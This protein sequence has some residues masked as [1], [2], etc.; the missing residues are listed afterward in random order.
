MDRKQNPSAI[1]ILLAVVVLI[2]ATAL[3]FDRATNL[4]AR[5]LDSLT[6]RSTAKA[7]EVRD[8]FVQL[9]QLQPRIT[10]NNQVFFEQTR[11]ALELAVV[12]RDTEVTQQTSHTWLGS[13]K[14]IR[15][16]AI[17]RVKAG[18]ALPHDLN[19][20]V[21]DQ[22]VIVKVPRATI[23]SVEPLSI[24]VEQ[25]QNGLWN[26]IQPQD[27]E[28]ELKAMPEIAR[29]KESTLP[30]EAQ[31]KFRELLTTKLSNLPL[32]IEIEPEN[33]QRQ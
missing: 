10:V 7:K 32:K 30:D 8:A 23:L 33:V 26:Q 12:N 31:Q 25:L 28:N 20:N 18:F 1:V 9:F 13:T 11:T 24:K 22:N 17:Y 14:T 5:M 21:S 15:I 27:V 19:V 4:P 29:S 2:L 6:N 16:H 3:A